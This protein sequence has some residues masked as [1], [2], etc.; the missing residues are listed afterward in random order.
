[1]SR[2][3]HIASSPISQNS[4]FR[5][6]RGYIEFLKFD[7]TTKK[8]EI[9]KS[10][11]IWRPRPILTKFGIKHHSVFVHFCTKFQLDKL[12]FAWVRQFWVNSQI[13]QNLKKFERFNRFL[14]NSLPKFLD[15]CYIFVCCFRMT[16]RILRKLE[17]PRPFFKKFKI[18]Y[19]WLLHCTKFHIDIS[20]GLWVIGVWNVENRAHTHTHTYIRMPA[21]N[22]IS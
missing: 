21:K 8:I 6:L 12:E 7:V 3:S 11:K 4:F 22:Y 20:S 2:D 10:S 1:M 5:K 9:S 18:P 13:I 19:L 15:W 14:P 16:A 17:L